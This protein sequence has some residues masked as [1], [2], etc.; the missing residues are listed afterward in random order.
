MLRID[1]DWTTGS[2]NMEIGD[3]VVAI[4]VRTDRGIGTLR[5]TGPA[6]PGL[7]NGVKDIQTGLSTR[8][9]VLIAVRQ[10]QRRV[11][12]EHPSM[13]MFRRS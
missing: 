5:I 1:S 9:L 3:D 6:G 4:L 10:D 11:I 12:F 8:Q 13:R 2:I 7:P